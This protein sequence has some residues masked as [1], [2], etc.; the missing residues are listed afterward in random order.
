MGPIGTGS[1]LGGGTGG[2]GVGGGTG[3]GGGSGGGGVGGGGVGGGVGAGGG[4]GGG[5]AAAAPCVALIVSPAITRD[6]RRAA[7]PLADTDTRT[8]PFPL[9]DAGA[10]DAQ[11]TSLRAVQAQAEWPCTSTVSCPP[12]APIVVA[13]GMTSYRHGAGLCAMEIE[14][15]ATVT[16]PCLATGSAFSATR[17]PT[18]PSPCPSAV[19][20][21]AIHF[22]CDAAR[23]E[24][25][26]AT[27]TETVPV[28]PVAPNVDTDELTL[29]S[30]RDDASDG[31]V[32][33][34]DV[35]LPQPVADTPKR[36]ETDA[37]QRRR[38][39]ARAFTLARNA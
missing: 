13:L 27:A 39:P 15:S 8:T 29:G 26:R 11:A 3:G 6:T 7:P 28:P 22:A 14:R 23:Q 20:V 10:T 37:K 19:E 35:E 30:Q 2:G 38:S 31:L 36:T 16:A 32:T 4:G 33:L 21:T 5:G 12:A 18:L 34:V 1:G 24:H 17:N 9:P 25:S